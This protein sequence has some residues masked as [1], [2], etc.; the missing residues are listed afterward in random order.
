MIDISTMTIFDAYRELESIRHK[1]E[2]IEELRVTTGSISASKLSED[3]V[4]ISFISND[5][6]LN[7]IS[8]K[9]GFTDTLKRLNTLRIKYEK[10][11]DDEI[12]LRKL[13]QPQLIIAYLRDY[14]KK[15]WHEISRRM[16]YS[17]R[18]CK[19]FYSEYKG[20]TPQENCTN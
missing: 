12:E 17:I 18:Q 9:D 14:L 11:I 13:S 8:K 10:F 6:I 7:A 15:D 20:K 16:D 4:Q 2:L 3:K 19:R 5:S 1:K